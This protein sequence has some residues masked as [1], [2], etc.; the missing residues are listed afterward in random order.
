MRALATAAREGEL[1]NLKTLNLS[2]NTLT[3][4]LLD[5]FKGTKYL[6]KGNFEMLESLLLEDTHLST[7]DILSLSTAICQDKLPDLQHLNISQQNLCDLKPA[8]INLIQSCARNRERKMQLNIS[9]SSFR[10]ELQDKVRSLCAE[11]KVIV[12]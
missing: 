4:T 8:L 9:L 5:L 1:W 11:S 6:F 2:K 10:R 3:D 12:L 7:P